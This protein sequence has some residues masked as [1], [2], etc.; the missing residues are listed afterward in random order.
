[1]KVIATLIM[2]LG[3]TAFTLQHPPQQKQEDFGLPELHRIN[4]ITLSPSYSC[5][6]P[7]DFELGY[8]D[9]A[10]FLSDYSRRRKEPEL[11]FNGACGAH[12]NLQGVSNS[13]GVIADLGEMPLEKLTAH[14]IFNTR[15]VASFDLYSKFA[16][17]VPVR[18]HHTYAVLTHSPASRSMFVF[19]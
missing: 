12:D 19:T 16:A 17:S 15:N 2:F 5:R 11:V 10:L 7:G 4:T 6:P 9:T 14:L 3:F 8:E 18:L 13:Y 1:M